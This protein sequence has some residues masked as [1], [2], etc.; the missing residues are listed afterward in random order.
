MKRVMM[1]LVCTLMWA[2]S[3]AQ[4]TIIKQIK[5]G[6]RLEGPR[7]D[8]LQM[9]DGPYEAV[10]G[11]P[12]AG[13]SLIIGGD[14]KIQV[15]T[16]YDFDVAL[17]QK[18]Y[19]K[20]SDTASP[21]EVNE[22]LTMYH[23]EQPQLAILMYNLVNKAKYMY[24]ADFN[25]ASQ[26][27]VTAIHNMGSGEKEQLD[28]HDMSPV[29][30]G[31]PDFKDQL[32]PTGTAE[33][34]LGVRCHIYECELETTVDTA[35]APVLV[36][37]RVWIPE[38]IHQVFGGYIHIREP[39]RQQLQDISEAGK[40]LPVAVPLRKELR[41]SDGTLLYTVPW[42]MITQEPRRLNV[43]DIIQASIHS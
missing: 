34:I 14:K 35:G 8:T 17:Y 22:I 13:P 4:E 3:M 25:H 42:D 12:L 15:D 2:A 28:L 10:G 24:I 31:E 30:P 5:D 41:Y 7:K 1:L 40:L 6:F 37:A 23:S 38:N 18:V 19:R 32:Q 27:S 21:Q 20:T 33:E 43:S 29:Y 11:K 36:S 39:Y 9:D 26:V 16:A